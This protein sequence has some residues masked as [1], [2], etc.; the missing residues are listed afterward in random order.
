MYSANPKEKLWVASK[1]CKYTQ[2]IE[3]DKRNYKQTK[4]IFIYY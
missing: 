3:R 1:N 2:K 4:D